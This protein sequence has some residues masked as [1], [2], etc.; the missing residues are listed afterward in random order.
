[1]KFKKAMNGLLFSTIFTLSLSTMTFATTNEEIPSELI[2]TQETVI[3]TEDVL[4]NKQ[5]EIDRYV[6]ETNA[7]DIT[8]KGFMVTHTVVVNDYVEVGILPFTQENANYI[9]DIFR[10]EQVK[11]VEGEEA[12]IMQYSTNGENLPAS[13][14]MVA[15]EETV[16]ITEA[17]VISTTND[18]SNE[19][20]LSLPVLLLSGAV[21]T[22]VLALAARKSV[23]K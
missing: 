18:G 4:G 22:A 3:N 21:I 23:N 17:E 14:G 19:T 9:Y 15:D 2:A 11:V 5:M 8:E 12:E 6:F 10:N 20:V 7:N 13:T 1:M 16:E